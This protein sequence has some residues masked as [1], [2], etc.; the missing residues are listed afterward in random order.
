MFEQR[1]G[2]VGGMC[3]RWVVELVHCNNVGLDWVE[4]LVKSIEVGGEVRSGRKCSF[5]Y[6]ILHCESRSHE[7]KSAV[8]RWSELETRILRVRFQEDTQR[9]Q[10]SRVCE[11]NIS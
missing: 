7:R 2:W 5:E 11:R 3:C 8:C 10:T 1:Y 9:W 4:N 6:D